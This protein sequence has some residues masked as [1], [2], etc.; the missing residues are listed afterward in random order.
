M[1]FWHLS[2]ELKTT[3]FKMNNNTLLLGA[4]LVKFLK[5]KTDICGICSSTKHDYLPPGRE[6]AAHIF[7]FCPRL[8][9]LRWFT[10]CIFDVNNYGRIE[11]KDLTDAGV[12]SLSQ[13][14]ATERLSFFVIFLNFVYRFRTTIAVTK[15]DFFEKYYLLCSI[16]NPKEIKTNSI[17][18]LC[19]S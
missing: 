2:S 8:S 17:Q 6:T 19:I 11:F 5:D 7:S 13:T 15:L 4:Q 3:F 14:K 1:E 12:P 10:R 18:R 9:K 16:G